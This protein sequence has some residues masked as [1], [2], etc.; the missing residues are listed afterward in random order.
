MTPEELQRLL[1]E[2]PVGAY[3]SAS[4]GHVEAPTERFATRH[5]SP[6]GKAM[7]G[8]PRSSWSNGDEVNEMGRT[9]ERE[10]RRAEHLA[11]AR[12]RVIAAR[13]ALEPRIA[14]RLLSALRRQDTPC[15]LLLGP[16]G[17]GKTSAAHWLRARFG[18]VL[19][20]ASELGSSERR[21]ALGK[22]YSPEIEQAHW[23]RLL[24][25]DDLGTEDPRDISVLQSVIDMRYSSGRALVTTTGLTRA[26]LS[27]RYDA[28]MVRRLHDQHVKRPD[29][30]RDWPVLV[31][32][33]HEAP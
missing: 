26:M 18:G 6:S 32:D 1:D 27:E 4:R 14:P 31:V 12:A 23:C 20:R 24:I 13:R 22:G 15:A 5:M 33:L 8:G 9:A 19:I 25:I 29:G 16:T 11:Q 21:H 17:C 2:R 10:Q 30:G 3:G 28:P 7:M